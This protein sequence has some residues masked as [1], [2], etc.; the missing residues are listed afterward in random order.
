MGTT[1]RQWYSILS[2]D[3]CVFSGDGVQRRAQLIWIC[4]KDINEN[5][6]R[7]IDIKEPKKCFY[8]IHF[9]SDFGC[10]QYFL[11]ISDFYNLFPSEDKYIYPHL[12]H[13]FK[14]KWDQIETNYFYKEFTQLGYESALKEL[15][16][17]SS[18]IMNTTEV[19]IND[20]SF[21]SKE[22]CL[23]EFGLLKEQNIKLQQR[24]DF[25]EKQF[26]NSDNKDIKT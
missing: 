11:R 8:E 23:Q 15:F 5:I 19:G 6:D 7:V 4:G 24:I 17:E 3:F 20:L 16:I 22:K 14:S 9:A 25:L 10:G 18:I 13:E 2:I 21:E 1:G 26:N 12:S